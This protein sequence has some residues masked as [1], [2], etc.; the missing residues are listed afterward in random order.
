MKSL[1][2]TISSG[3][4]LFRLGK[5][6]DYV[7]A[8]KAAFAVASGVCGDPLMHACDYLRCPHGT[9]PWTLDPCV[10]WYVECLSSPLHVLCRGTPRL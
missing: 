9:P 7:K 3:R 8:L 6:V 10:A 5:T 4:R 2:A 1:A